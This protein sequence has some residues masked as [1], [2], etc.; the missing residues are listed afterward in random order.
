[1]KWW[2]SNV[3]SSPNFCR[4]HQRQSTLVDFLFLLFVFSSAS[5][6]LQQHFVH[7]RNYFTEKYTNVYLSTWNFCATSFLYSYHS[8]LCLY[9]MY[10]VYTYMNTR[11]QSG[12][13]YLGMRIGI[14]QTTRVFTCYSPQNDYVICECT[15]KYCFIT[16]IPS[17]AVSSY[18]I[19]IHCE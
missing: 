8:V 7:T 1:M 5:M 9:T 15:T 13:T 12:Q 10:N 19:F 17:V 6:C 2:N 4:H 16:K 3:V 14:L 18:C 11:S